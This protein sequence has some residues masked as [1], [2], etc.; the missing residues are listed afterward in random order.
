MSI[1]AARKTE[2][3]PL[4]RTDEAAS[5]LGMTKKKLLELARSREIGSVRDRAARGST[6]RFRMSQLNAWI[7]AHEVK[8]LR[9]L[10]AV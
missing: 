1:H 5:Y 10:R 9:P 6:V 2:R 7:E 8:P 4:L 3:D